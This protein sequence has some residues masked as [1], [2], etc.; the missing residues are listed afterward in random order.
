MTNEHHYYCP[1][2]GDKLYEGNLELL[3]CYRCHKHFL[4]TVGSDEVTYMLTWVDENDAS[5]SATKAYE[6]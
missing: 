5:T 2:C 1:L 4:P 3:Q 6:L